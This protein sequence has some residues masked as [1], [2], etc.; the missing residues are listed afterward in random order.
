MTA[1]RIAVKVAED[2][3]VSAQLF[4][5][6]AY[7]PPRPTR[8]RAGVERDLIRLFARWL[9]VRE[10]QWQA[11]ELRA[12][13]TLLHQALFP[14]DVWEW[15]ERYVD[16][17]SAESPVRLTLQF[18]TEPPFSTYATLPWEYLFVPERPERQG[19]F[20]S[21]RSIL[22][23]SRYVPQQSGV[24]AD[25]ALTA[26]QTRVL[27]VVSNPRTNKLAPVDALEVLD[28]LRT[29]A[30]TTGFKLQIVENL[31]ARDVSAKIAEFKPHLVHFMGHGRFRANVN[32]GGLAFPDPDEGITWINDRDLEQIFTQPGYAP[33][34]VV[35]HACD[36]GATAFEAA[37][38]GVA[39]TLTRLGVQC[40]VAMQYPITNGVAKS[41]STT[42]YSQL[43]QHGYADV[44]AQAARAII[45]GGPELSNPRNLGIPVVYVRA[46]EPLFVPG[47]GVDSLAESGSGEAES[48]SGRDEFLIEISDRDVVGIYSKP[49][50]TD[51]QTGPEQLDI[52]G[53]RRDTIR[54]F[55]DWLNHWEVLDTLLEV[56]PDALNQKLKN[57][58][59]ST[60]LGEAQLKLLGRQLWSLVLDNKVG[61]QLVSALEE[62]R[63]GR[64]LRVSISFVGSDQLVKGLPWEF[65]YRPTSQDSQNGDFV[66]ASGDLVLSRVIRST[67]QSFGLRS[68]PQNEQLGV[69][70]VLAMPEDSVFGDEYH[71]ANGMVRLLDQSLDGVAAVSDGRWPPDQPWA[72]A[73][74]PADIL[75]IVGVCRGSVGAPKLFYASSDSEH[76]EW[77]EPDQLLALLRE[78]AP[79]GDK[80]RGTQLV[81]LQLC[82]W[83]TD[84]ASDNFERLAPQ[85]IEQ[86]IPAVLAM[87]YPLGAKE[88]RSHIVGFYRNLANGDTVGE[89]VQ[90]LRG[91]LRQKQNSRWFGAP[92]L[93]LRGADGPLRGRPGPPV[94]EARPQTAAQLPPD[95]VV[96]RRIFILVEGSEL[97]DLLK[98]EII[99]WVMDAGWTPQ[100]MELRVRTLERNAGADKPLRS[101]CSTVLK[102][103]HD[104][105]GGGDGRQHT[106]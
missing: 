91:S 76:G 61:K 81:V 69:H 93:Y 14:D 51:A 19:Y 33:R 44:A 17:G 86:G 3:V 9:T 41:F 88:V 38:A 83:R 11:D 70:F 102:E 2:G 50:L 45:G 4:S 59:R 84:D 42:F 96:R 92:V 24:V 43:V 37:Y 57:Q 82:D 27:A 87:Q 100:A 8:L 1:Y 75:H 106:A 35:L 52:R 29:A 39:T 22:T 103:L 54:V 15:V 90:A 65:L 26:A 34:I 30:Q 95:G 10:W 67:N 104:Y 32:S 46:V 105:Q 20:L 74:I 28:A 49:G 85:V 97:E 79:S 18:P 94:I 23:L 89:A 25:P 5:L 48:V 77:R 7:S 68:V 56:W 80:P 71:R 55:D 16:K 99:G 21:T 66:S 98:Q 31:Q 58:S 12:F 62:A 72:V 6:Q 63:P 53:L 73:E 36:G 64:K 13:G 40:V 78:Y 101:V 60:L 47:N